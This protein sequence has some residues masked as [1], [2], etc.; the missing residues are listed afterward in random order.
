MPKMFYSSF[1]TSVCLDG[2]IVVCPKPQFLGGVAIAPFAC[3][4][5]ILET[6]E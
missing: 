1:S 4:S 5:S 2:L 3:Q 6:C